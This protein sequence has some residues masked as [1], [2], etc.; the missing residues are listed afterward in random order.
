MT[1]TSLDGAYAVAAGEA[2]WRSARTNRPVD[3]D[4]LLGL[5]RPDSRASS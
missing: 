5:S 4:E 3:V 2:L 1:A